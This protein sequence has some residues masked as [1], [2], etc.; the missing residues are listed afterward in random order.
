MPRL[1][2]VHLPDLSGIRLPDLSGI[3]LPDLSKITLPD[4]NDISLPD[5]QAI[6]VPEIDVQIF[7][8]NLFKGESATVVVA[9]IGFVVWV[10]L[11]FLTGY[12][13]LTF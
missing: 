10:S 3:R 9:T 1:S 11:M 7:F 5:L 12:S 13:Y 4:L 8:R 2:H 6:K